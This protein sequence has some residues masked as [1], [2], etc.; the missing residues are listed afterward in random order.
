MRNKILAGGLSLMIMLS[1]IPIKSAEAY[2]FSSEG[3]CYAAV[4]TRWTQYTIVQEDGSLCTWGDGKPKTPTTKRYDAYTV[5][6]EYFVKKD[7]TLWLLNPKHSAVQV[8]LDF[9]DI[10]AVK[11]GYNTFAVIRKDNSLWM[12]GD[13]SSGRL[14]NGQNTQRIKP[15]KIMDNVVAVN[16]SNIGSY[17]IK[18]D[19]SL[20]AWG[21]YLYGG[22]QKSSVPVKI[23]D[24]VK[25]ITYGMEKIAVLKTDNTVWGW[26]NNYYGELTDEAD[27]ETSLP[28]K[29]MS[30]VKAVSMGNYHTAFLKLD[31]SLWMSGYNDKGQLGNN[32]EGDFTIG[33]GNPYQLKPIK[34]MDN[35]NNVV[36]GI[37]STVAIK[38]DG[39]VWTWGQRDEVGHNS[40]KNV[41]VPTQLD[42]VIAKI[43]PWTSSQL[44]GEKEPTKPSQ[45]VV[46][47]EEPSAW[48]KS[49]VDAARLMELIPENIDNNYRNPITRL[50]F[51]Q[52]A[53]K[54]LSVRLNKDI[55]QLLAEVP[56]MP[57]AFVD[58]DD[59]AIQV[60]SGYGIVNGVGEGLFAPNKNIT[61]EQAATMLGRLATYL[62]V[63]KGN[64]LNFNDSKEF[65]SWATES[66]YLVS[67]LVDGN[68]KRVMGGVAESVFSPKTTYTREQAIC[69]FMRLCGVN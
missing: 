38:N 7:G 21:E 56:Y 49:E 27:E 1:I 19:G 66:I 31:G 52:L 11:Y 68:N 46:V 67:S 39:T 23:M 3:A 42:G 6:G 63:S 41:L 50:E 34:I 64:S 58:T 33:S 57:Q 26:G 62:K 13:N 25:G 28:V 43:I 54:L 20:W 45:P 32:F 5:S 51:A 10:I 60:A 9:N 4:S 2:D 12:W 55:N 30:D 65:S 40:G 8:E 61:R 14:G 36:A 35:V 69:S 53:T 48:A 15:V 47:G 44:G 59:V 16:L 24:D 29:I 37:E 22:W 18:D 17:A